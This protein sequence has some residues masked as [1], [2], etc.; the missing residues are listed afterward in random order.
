MIHTIRR[1]SSRLQQNEGHTRQIRH[2]TSY[3]WRLSPTNHEGCHLLGSGLLVSLQCHYRATNAQHVEGSHIHI[4]PT[5]E[6]P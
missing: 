2:I 3:H 6:V 4:S 5:T 1:T